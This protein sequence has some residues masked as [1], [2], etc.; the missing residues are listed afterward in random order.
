[1]KICFIS[2]LF[3]DA[4][5]VDK[6][7]EFERISGCD[8]FLYT[9]IEAENFATSWDVVHLENCPDVENMQSSIR[10][11]RY[12][13]FLAWK[14][15]ERTYDL[16]VYCDAYLAPNPKSSWEQINAAVHESEFGLMQFTHGD[17]AVI[18][19]GLIEE[20]KQIVFWDRDTAESMNATIDF[21]RS[22][23]PEV[24]LRKPGFYFENTV[25]AYDPQNESYQK[26][27]AEFWEIYTQEA[28]TYRDQPL[29]NFLLLKNSFVPVT[30]DPL[31]EMFY[32]VGR[33][34]KMRK[35]YTGDD[36][37]P[38]TK[39][40]CI[41]PNYNHARFLP[42]R[43]DSILAQTRMPDEIILLDDQS[44]DNS[45]E[46]LQEY[47][48]RFPLLISCHFNEEN[49]GSP[50]KQW[51]KGMELA[52]GDF[53]WIAESDDVADP[54]L[55]ETLAPMLEA[56]PKVGIAY[57]QSRKIGDQGEDLGDYHYLTEKL[58]ADHWSSAYSNDGRDECA[59]Y[60]I[61]MNTIANASAVLFRKAAYEN[62]GD[63]PSRFRL[64]GDWL[65]WVRMLEKFDIAYTP[66]K[67]SSFRYHESSVRGTTQEEKYLDE[68]R[69]VRQHIMCHFDVL[70]Q[71]LN[72]VQHSLPEFD[73]DMQPQVIIEAYE[74]KLNDLFKGLS[75]E[76][77]NPL[78]EDKNIHLPLAQR[79]L[80]Y[81]NKSFSAKK[82]KLA[83]QYY[84]ASLRYD[85]LRLKAIG[86]AMSTY[87][88][89]CRSI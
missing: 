21:F 49:S 19:N 44:S 6:P 2:S 25:F 82:F 71:E 10:K 12:A 39:I 22:L 74:E 26:Q 54:R 89:W 11:S 9:D 70:D 81:G 40:T 53:I 72:I 27:S 77:L 24:D 84:A 56:D 20:M 4:D 79:L 34:G 31:K 35:A 46:I 65:V 88:P 86:Y 58:D 17:K 85:R 32:R 30:H 59:K 61:R 43:L 8:Y 47:A 60:L 63:E 7:G 55:L 13:K 62:M 87:A 23:A 1:M 75:E 16:V 37:T 50:F 76:K 67:L 64:C 73:A 28:I 18:E 45:C 41:V 69:R 78:T 52:H 48:E 68:S 15:L 80:D 57:C 29:W 83:R 38:K 51:A 14:I 5:K 3:G 42:E 66:E 33:F 36:N